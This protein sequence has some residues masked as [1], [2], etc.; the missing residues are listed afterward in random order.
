MVLGMQSCQTLPGNVRINGRRG[1]VRVTEQE[2]HRT[3]ICT[4]V[5]Q[6]RRKRMAQGVG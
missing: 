2:L 6:M 4:V 5:E 3:Q 1:N